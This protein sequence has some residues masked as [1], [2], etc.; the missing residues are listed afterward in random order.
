MIIMV[1]Y[2][3]KYTYGIDNLKELIILHWN[4]I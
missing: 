4:D 1:Y 2:E 3:K